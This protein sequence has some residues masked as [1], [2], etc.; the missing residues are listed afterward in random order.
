MPYTVF[1]DAN[2]N[3]ITAPNESGEIALDTSISRQIRINVYNN[4]Y[5]FYDIIE[6]KTLDVLEIRNID[7][8]M[9]HFTA[10]ID[11]CS[12]T[13]IAANEANY[14]IVYKFVDL[15]LGSTLSSSH[16][17]D[18]NGEYYS[19]NIYFT[20]NSNLN[21]ITIEFEFQLGVKIRLN[22]SPKGSSP[23]SLTSDD[24]EIISLFQHNVTIEASYRYTA[25]STTQAKNIYSFSFSFINN[26]SEEYTKDQISSMLRDLPSGDKYPASGLLY[27]GLYSNGASTMSIAVYTIRYIYRSGTSLTVN[28]LLKD[29]SSES[30]SATTVNSRNMA[31]YPNSMDTLTL[32]DDVTQVS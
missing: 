8:R 24:V 31:I 18:Y 3:L 17:T 26:R 30:S 2:D 15:C 23:F 19:D 14:P 5:S 4:H 1:K 10:I 12:A 9:C 6:K 29:T 28:A 22:L 27:I 32:N 13:G 21:P 20:N 11:P 25:T 7:P 16:I